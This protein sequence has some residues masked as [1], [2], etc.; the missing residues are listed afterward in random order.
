M[1]SQVQVPLATLQW[2]TAPVAVSSRT[3]PAPDESSVK[4]GFTISA[5]APELHAAQMVA[6]ASRPVRTCLVMPQPNPAPA[7]GEASRALAGR[8]PAG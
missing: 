1:G 3:N 6:T 4:R 7:S 8:T 2:V 5:A